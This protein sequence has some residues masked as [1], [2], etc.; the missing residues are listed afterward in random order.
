M[1]IKYKRI[2]QAVG[3]I[4]QEQ[5]EQENNEIRVTISSP[6]LKK[7]T[8]RQVYQCCVVRGARVSPSILTPKA[9]RETLFFT[10]FALSVK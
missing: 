6:G 8:R 5:Y 9:K 3:G 2:S 4:S 1:Y 10:R 7:H